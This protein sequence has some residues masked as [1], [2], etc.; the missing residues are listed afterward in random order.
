ML[1]KDFT[2]EVSVEMVGE[3]SCLEGAFPFPYLEV[4]SCL[5]EEDAFLEVLSSLVV[6]QEQEVSYHLASYSFLALQRL[7][8][9][10][11]ILMELIVLMG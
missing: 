4:A 2:V 5:E 7:F 3:A 1:I 10:H 6:N 9:G 11:L 8:L